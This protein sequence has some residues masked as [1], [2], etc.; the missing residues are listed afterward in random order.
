[1]MSIYYLDIVFPCAVLSIVRIYFTILDC[2]AVKNYI[3]VKV[4]VG[5]V[6]FPCPSIFFFFYVWN[7]ILVINSTCVNL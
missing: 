2:H 6:S 4:N 7:A 3:Y 1:M 5:F